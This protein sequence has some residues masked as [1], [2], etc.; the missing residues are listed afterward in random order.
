MARPVTRMTAQ[1]AEA[2]IS[3]GC[4]D[5]LQILQ[6]AID[7]HRGRSDSPAAVI[8][9]AKRFTQYVTTGE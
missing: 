8:E 5:R 2:S 7:L 9:T 4:V 3:A 1:P 6:M